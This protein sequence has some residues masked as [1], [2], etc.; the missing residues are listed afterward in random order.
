MSG[1]GRTGMILRAERAEEGTELGTGR[2]IQE[3]IKSC[4]VVWSPELARDQR[5]VGQVGIG[6]GPG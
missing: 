2:A 1:T 6:E 4:P 3:K 5:Q